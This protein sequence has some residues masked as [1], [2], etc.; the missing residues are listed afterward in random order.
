M[1]APLVPALLPDR[2]VFGSGELFLNSIHV[3][4]LK[5]ASLEI[6]EEEVESESGRPLVTSAIATL[7]QKAQFTAQSAE[8]STRSVRQALSNYGTATGGIF[9]EVD[10]VAVALAGIAVS[11]LGHGNIVKEDGTAAT[12]ADITV[13]A[14]D[15]TVY[16]ATEYVIDD[17]SGTI[18]RVTLANADPKD[19]DIADGETVVV[20]FA[21]NSATA[22]VTHFGGGQSCGALLYVPLR[23]VYKFQNCDQL[24]IFLHKVKP[25]GGLK[26]PFE[27]ESFTTRDLLFKAVA[28]LTKP[29][30]FQ[31]GY[32]IMTP[33]V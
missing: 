13:I 17:V 3:G 26:A 4:E 6:P 2:K 33:A 20:Y 16:P 1:S 28:D 10:G 27:T 18:R 5:N 24:E 14:L 8:L 32:V 29:K 21:W 9:H 31:Y 22:E 23:F 12:E 30:G 11:S 15:G 19:S 25:S 7:R